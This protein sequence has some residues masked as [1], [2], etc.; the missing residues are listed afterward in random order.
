MG[1]L[2]WDTPNKVILAAS[3]DRVS[4]I[5]IRRIERKQK[6][7]TLK[8][9]PWKA[10]WWKRDLKTLEFGSAELHN[11]KQ[12]RCSVAKETL[13]KKKHEVSLCSVLQKEGRQLIWLLNNGVL[14]CLCPAGSSSSSWPGWPRTRRCRWSSCTGRWRGTRGKGWVA[15]EEEKGPGGGSGCVTSIKNPGLIQW[16][17]LKKQFCITL[18]YKFFRR[19]H[20]ERTA[21]GV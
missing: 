19:W 14:L 17:G 5:S 16:R 9:N 10:T 21:F 7:E 20:G 12:Q 13:I 6:K 3:V 1:P 4:E 8:R 18:L 15:A 11:K 2:M